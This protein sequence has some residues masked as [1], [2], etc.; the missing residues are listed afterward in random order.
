MRFS[1]FTPIRLEFNDWNGFIF[2][3]FY[4]GWGNWERSLFSIDINSYGIQLD[5]IFVTIE[6]K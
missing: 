4:I 1:R 5:I 6:I 2:E 3:V